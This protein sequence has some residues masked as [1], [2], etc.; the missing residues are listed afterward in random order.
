MSLDISRMADEANARIR[1][2]VNRVAGQHQRRMRES[3]PARQSAL[4]LASPV[5]MDLSGARGSIVFSDS[6]DMP[7]PTGYWTDP[8]DWWPL[9][10]REVALFWSLAAIATTAWAGIAIA[11]WTYATKI[12][13]AATLASLTA[14]VL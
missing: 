1:L 6:G 9:T 7:D 4:P 5:P 3:W 12:D 2:H 11:V 8:D 10:G 14:M 13:P